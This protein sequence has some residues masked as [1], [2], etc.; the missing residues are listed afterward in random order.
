MRLPRLENLAQIGQLQH[1]PTVPRELW[2]LL[3]SGRARLADAANVS[4]ALESRFDLAY[5][6]AHAFALAALR[7]HGYRAS[8]RYVVFQSLEDTAGIAPNVWRVLAH[9]HHHRNLMEYEG[10]GEIART[11]ASDSKSR[12]VE[13][14]LADRRG[15]STAPAPRAPLRMTTSASSSG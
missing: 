5:N 13:G 10:G 2:A 7:H 15:P 3:A 1:S 11:L 12:A 6:A 8:N 4:L 14:F 9:A